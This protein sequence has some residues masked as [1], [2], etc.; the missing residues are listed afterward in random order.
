[1]G[2]KIKMR[3]CSG[4]LSLAL[5]TSPGP[6]GFN[7]AAHEPAAAPRGAAKNHASSPRER[8][9][10]A[11]FRAHVEAALA[12]AK[13]AKAY[14]GI[15][16]ADADTGET[17]YALNPDRLFA[18]ASTLKLF[19]AALA[20]SA[21]GPDYRFRT[22]IE[23]PGALGSDGIV[24]GDL[25]LVG[26]GDPDISNRKF[27]YDKKAEYDG[28]AE[29]VL[30]EL[31]EGVAA[32][33]VKQVEG[34]IVADDSYFPYDP[35]PPDWTYGDLYFEFGAPLTA[36]TLNENM[37]VYEVRPGPRAGDPAVVTVEPGTD[38]TTIDTSILTA[39]GGTKPK[40]SVVRQPGSHSILLRGAVPLDAGMISKQLA[41]EQPAETCAHLL[42]QLLEARG[43]HIS[44]AAKV[45]HGP[46]R[47]PDPVPG[48]PAP[49][50]LPPNSLLLAQHFSPPLIESVRLM[51]KISQNLHAELFLRTVAREKSGAGTTDAGIEVT[52]DFLKTIGIPEGDAVLADGSGLSP[53]DLVTPRA[54]VELLRYA[55]RQP[56]GEQFI[57]SLPVAGEDGTLETRMK[58]SP[59]EGRVRAKTGAIEHVRTLAG[60][61][62][63]LRG[64]HLIFSIF[65]NAA[66]DA[67]RDAMAPL[68]SI[69]VAMVEDI[70][71]ARGERK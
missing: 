4:M 60:Y 58:G 16:V 37:L 18:P 71:A 64:A 57:A 27:P 32:R 6:L 36:L 49:A 50:P 39:S 23:S 15:L 35:Y 20:L 55:Q 70:A 3:L 43:V 38:I 44:G 14:W 1:M 65:A 52:K 22:T 2:L 42:K 31:A 48:L 40:F 21:L 51:N 28:P 8:A 63:T 13:A 69:A 9:D 7:T 67:G 30:L 66:T 12:G 33:G 68:D 41:M 56:W 34:D 59:A 10:V 62:T 25:I 17:L 53:T 46:P 26:R 11:K 24:N 19:T 29:K 54:T 5:A 61:A 45:R 47:D